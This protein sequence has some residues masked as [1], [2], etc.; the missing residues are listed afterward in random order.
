VV[1]ARSQPD[2]SQVAVVDDAPAEQR[3][4]PAWKQVAET[5]QPDFSQVAVV[6]DAPRSHDRNLLESRLQ[7]P[8]NLTS[9]RL[10]FVDDVRAELRLQPA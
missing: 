6:D 4:Q 7:K 3:P 5:S 8:R 10:Q 9:V 2:F 1:S